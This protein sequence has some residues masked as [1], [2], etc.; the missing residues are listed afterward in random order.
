MLNRFDC[1]AILKM[2]YHHSIF[3][4][5]HSHQFFIAHSQIVSQHITKRTGYYPLGHLNLRQRLPASYSDY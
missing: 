4:R 1:W 5:P 2:P 3:Y